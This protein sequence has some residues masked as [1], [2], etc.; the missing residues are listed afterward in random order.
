MTVHDDLS[1]HTITVADFQEQLELHGVGLHELGDEAVH[2]LRDALVTRE[3]P[4][5]KLFEAIALAAEAVA[6]DLRRGRS[7]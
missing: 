6:E 2:R 3:Q 1:V 5:W 4:S 7:S